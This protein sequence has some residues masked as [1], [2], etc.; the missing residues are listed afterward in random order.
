[1]EN[2]FCEMKKVMAQEALLTLPD[3]SKPFEIFTDASGYQLG[4]VLQQEGKPLTYYTRKLTDT[5]RRYTT[6]KR[7]LLSIV[8]TLKEFKRMILGCVTQVYTDHLNLVHE[9]TAKASDRVMRWI[10]LLEEFG[11]QTIHIKGE[12]NVVAD[13]LSRLDIQTLKDNIAKEVNFLELMLAEQ[14]EECPLALE[15]IYLHQKDCRD[16]RMLR[17]EEGFYKKT[18]DGLSL[19]YTSEDQLV[20]PKSLQKKII[21]WYHH[22]LLHPGASKMY[23]TIKQKLWWKGMSADIK[24]HVAACATC[25]KFK[26]SRTKHGKLPV[27]DV[28]Q[29]VIPWDTVQIDSIGPYSITTCTGITL[30]LSCKTMI[31]PATGWLEITEMKDTNN[32]ADASRIFNNTWLSRYPRPKR[33][34]YDNGVEFKCHFEPL[35]KTYG[36]KLKK[37]IQ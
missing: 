37:K 2:A 17:L 24:R 23:N 8:E 25:K 19:L 15:V 11:I 26:N 29:E 22:F 27:K 1:M 35:L 34:I 13:T 18:I 12:R 21:E 9:T 4:A 10:L 16:T 33:I 5:Q 31:D 30:K 20:I 3:Y 28:A 7:E 6:E 32:S 14:D 36:V